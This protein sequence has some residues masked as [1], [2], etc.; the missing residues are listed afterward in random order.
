M[1]LI[2]NLLFIT[3][4]G[5]AACNSGKNTN[6]ELKDKNLLSTNL[7]NNPHSA[8]GVDAKTLAEMPTM[9][10]VDTFHNFGTM[11]EGETVTYDFAFKNNGKSP[12]IISNA[13]GSCGCTVPQFPNK[14]V[15]PG[16]S[17][18]IKVSFNSTG[19]PNHQEKT[20]T[21]T[22]NSTRGTL[23][24]NIKADVIPSENN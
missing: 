17:G 10:F 18:V 3:L 15:Q 6:D 22:T 19:K 2:K 24:L 20:V 4:V 23:L 14:P 7:V 16:E 11:H 13:V 21:I 8:E 5:L 1:A 9:D 12:L